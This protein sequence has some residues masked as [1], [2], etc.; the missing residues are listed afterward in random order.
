MPLLEAFEVLDLP[1]LS[2]NLFSS[3]EWLTVI[4]KTYQIKLFVKYIE[5]DGKISSAIIFS[6]VKNFLEWKICVGSYCDYFDCHVKSTDH[7]HLFFESLRSDYPEYRIAIRNLKDVTVR[8]CSDF[9]LLSKE[10]HHQLDIRD[11]IDSIWK[12]THRTFKSA[13]NRARNKELVIKRCDQSTLP[14]FYRLHLRLRKNKYK[15]FPQP[16][17]FFE[18]IWEEY[19][20]KDKGVLLGGYDK[21]GKFIAAQ[22]FLVC[23]DTLFYKFSTSNL[24]GRIFKPNNLLMWEGIKYAKERNLNYV[25]LGS[26]GY[27]QEGLIWFKTHICKSMTERDIHHIGF[28]PEN[29]KFSQ[30]RILKLYTKI[31]TM[32]WVPDFMV[33][34]GSNFIYPFLA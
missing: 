13:C 11:D 4:D 17:R 22:I 23:G 5:E 6:V 9:K 33:Q 19:I 24:R 10:R 29:Y 26:S 18:N 27:E 34:F 8:S 15:I 32:R 7:W 30:K 31:F 2:A 21:Q 12:N 14:E 1:D 3:K 20:A 16:Y 28:A 25:D